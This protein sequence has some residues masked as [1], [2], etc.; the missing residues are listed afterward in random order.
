MLKAIHYGICWSVRLRGSSILRQEP[1][2]LGGA[3]RLRKLPKG[4][5]V[6]NDEFLWLKS[7]TSHMGRSA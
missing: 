2:L 3:L 5:W 6:A 7:G 4:D 1:T